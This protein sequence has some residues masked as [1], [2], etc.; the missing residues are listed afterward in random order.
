M[1]FLNLLIMAFAVSIDGF[2]CGF[3][4][5]LRKIKIPLASLLAISFYS[6]LFCTG[7]MLLGRGL[8][9]SL[10]SII[11]NLI[12]AGLLFLLGGLTLRQILLKKKRTNFKRNPQNP[13][14]VLASPEIADL[15]GQKDI[16]GGEGTLLGIAVAIDAAIASFSLALIGYSP[17]A[18]PW[19]FGLFQFI[20]LGLGNSIPNRKGFVNLGENFSFLSVIFFILLGILRL[21]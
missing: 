18:A 8:M 6:V 20:L 14:H 11:G 17:W 21:I 12:S 13:I 15:D 3:A 4:M 19:L 10:P 9:G 2:C 5:G 16:R 7:A 1:G